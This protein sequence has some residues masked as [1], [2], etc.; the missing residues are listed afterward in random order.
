MTTDNGAAGVA[1]EEVTEQ[2]TEGQVSG[3][4]LDA[5]ESAGTAEGAEASAAE[6]VDDGE[7]TFELIVPEGADTEPETPSTLPGKSI[8]DLQRE[9]DEAR[10][11]N[12]VTYMTNGESI[13][14]QTL[15]RLGVDDDAHDEIW[16][17]LRNIPM[18]VHKDNE[19]MNKAMRERAIQQ[20]L[21]EDEYKTFSSRQYEG[22]KQEVEAL[23]AI[24]EARANK[25]WSGTLWNQKT[26]EDVKK[27][28][29]DAQKR[30]FDKGRGVGE[31]TQEIASTGQTANGAGRSTGGGR[32]P[33]IAQ[34]TGMS[35]EQREELR[36]NDPDIET[37][38]M[39]RGR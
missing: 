20:A 11:R 17:T 32:I 27:F 37:K 26:P 16:Q 28:H 33:T 31:S 34:W 2:Q 3:S 1:T 6:A 18:A 4:E 21:P 9:Q 29:E 19:V 38:I 7:P 12:Y 24:G 5:L 35:L 22:R 14:K 30:Q 25:R 10:T 23:V 15:R 36:R 13:V 39:Q 8:D